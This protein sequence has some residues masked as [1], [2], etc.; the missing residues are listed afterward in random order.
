M[1]RGYF[2]FF[3]LLTFFFFGCKKKSSSVQA[4][5]NFQSQPET[6][7]QFTGDP[8]FHLLAPSDCGV[9]FVNEFKETSQL[10][11][12]NFQYMYNG[13]G[14]AIGDINNDDLPDIY[15]TGN[16]VNDR[17]YLN[18]GEMHFEDITSKCGIEN[19]TGW[20]N[21]VGIFDFNHDGWLDIYV[22]RGGNTKKPMDRTNY[23]YINNQ[24]MTFTESAMQFG[25][26]DGGASV[27][28]VCLDYD[29]D[30]DLDLYV[31]N[32]PDFFNGTLT[33]RMQMMRNPDYLISDHLYQNNSNGTF[34]DVTLQAG[35]QEFGHGLG[36]IVIDANQDGW[37]DI[38]VANDFQTP[39]YL[40]INNQNGTFTDK[41]K[42]YFPHCSFYSMGTDVADLNFDGFMDLIC[43]DM[44]P[45]N[46]Q[47]EALN[48]MEM[49]ESRKQ[50][51]ADSGLHHQ[52]MRNT[53]YLNSGNN[54]FS[55]IAQYAGVDAT[56]WSWTPLFADF[57]LDGL[58]DL[59]VT[60]GY[61]HDTQ[62]RDWLALVDSSVKANNW[63]T[64]PQ[65]FYEEHCPSVKLWN[66]MY[67]GIKDLKFE[68]H[69]QRW[70]FDQPTFSSGAAYGDLD[71]DG[72][73]DLVINN[74]M[75]TSFVYENTAAEKKSGNYLE[76][77][78]QGSEKNLFG[79]GTHVSVYA[80]NK[81]QYQVLFSTK[82]FQS[83]SEPILHFGLGSEVVIDKIE[84]TWTDGRQQ[85]L[86]DVNANQILTINYQDAKQPFFDLYPEPEQ[87]AY[88]TE[89]LK[90][91]IDFTHA[92][93]EF[94]DY[95]EY[96]L[97]P[98]KL[99]G[100]DIAI[101]VA[102]INRDGLKDF[103]VSAGGILQSKIS[104]Q[105]AGGGFTSRGF[106]ASFSTHG[107]SLH[108]VY[109]DLETDGTLH[110]YA[111]EHLYWSD[112]NRTSNEVNRNM[113]NFLITSNSTDTSD[114]DLDGD[115]D[116]FATDEIAVGHYGEIP[117]SYL[118]RNDN[119][120]FKDVTDS[121]APDLMFPGMVTDALWTDAD[122]DGD[123]DLLLVGEWMNISLFKNENGKLSKW[124][125]PA[126]EKTSGF[127][128]TIV[129]EDFDKDGDEDFVAGNI[130]TNYRYSAASD[131]PLKLFL[132][133]YFKNGIPEPYFARLVDGKYFPLRNEQVF[134][135]AFK[136]FI[137]GYGS[138]E[139]YS[140]LTV[141]ELF[142]KADKI[143]EAWIMESVYIR[144]DGEGNYTVTHLPYLAQLSSVNS[145]LVLDANIDGNADLLIAGNT[146]NSPWDIGDADAGTGLLL[147]GNGK[148]NFEPISVNESGFFTPGMV[149]DMEII[150]I[151]KSGNDFLV[152]VGN[153][154]GRMQVFRKAQ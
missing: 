77:K 37:D 136:N 86:T 152:I 93:E 43:V 139:N 70:G 27:Q 91:G 138:Y 115:L 13:G 18:K 65:E 116:L 147:L 61:L 87:S 121:I 7:K 125:I 154:D 97:Q 120:I 58:N 108:P 28:S 44:L 105:N 126:F 66:Y 3:L 67:R 89:I 4:V 42:E 135:N 137:E 112:S 98:Q 92:A 54:S 151:G 104:L 20:K 111:N 64:L 59:L 146:F 123:A 148:G 52:V 34:A 6:D 68:N 23:L 57:D 127:W 9:N 38:F 69:S 143:L 114:F 95:A 48:L 132:I 144:N 51:Y 29:H 21:G 26:A 36:P 53:L 1:I 141:E 96:L 84:I 106:D 39:D 19:Q 149:R 142:G 81:K 100:K 94:D 122:K 2:L 124:N 16:L 10:N 103:Y 41:L 128:N 150:P 33:Q 129:A 82:G 50:I 140:N 130:G 80:G 118:F 30:G 79:L 12:Y 75:D 22:C 117:R 62:N 24:D 63:K 131:M 32:H 72:D 49:N 76:I 133:D 11:F 78:C 83:S 31:A 145:I 45:E 113:K 56:D 25:I 74:L 134:E 15:F 8:L 90:S 5:Q 107:S 119:G 99:S 153:N 102:D 71:Q 46:Y 17:L 47:R 55:D 109:F 60:N 85:L 35:I 88:F 14:V 110:L 73:L 101:S 40:W